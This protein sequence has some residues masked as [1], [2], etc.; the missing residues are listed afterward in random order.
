MD[1]CGA[2]IDIDFLKDSIAMNLKIPK[3]FIPSYHGNSSLGHIGKIYEQR[4][5][6]QSWLP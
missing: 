6:W 1:N 4:Y 5:K 3:A 2:Y